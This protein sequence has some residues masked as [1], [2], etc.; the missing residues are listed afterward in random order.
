M[1]ALFRMGKTRL[2]EIK[3]KKQAERAAAG[4]VDAPEPVPQ[5][6]RR[7]I[8][9]KIKKKRPRVSLAKMK[10]GRK[11]LLGYSHATSRVKKPVATFSY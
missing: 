3:E 11:G 10:A 2:K 6:D 1:A 4:P 9:G 7:T 5:G 8:G